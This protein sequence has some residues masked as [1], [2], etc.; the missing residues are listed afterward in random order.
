MYYLIHLYS[1]N[2]IKY[3][4]MDFYNEN[5]LFLEIHFQVLVILW[6]FMDIFSNVEIMMNFIVLSRENFVDSI[7]RFLGFETFIPGV[8]NIN[9]FI[10]LNIVF[11][12]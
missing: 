12:S 11:K 9:I 8:F 1:G 4:S 6:M 5:W 7:A 3:F 10:N 2:S